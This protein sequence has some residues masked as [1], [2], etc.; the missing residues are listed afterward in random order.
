MTQD[1]PDAPRLR[2]AADRAVGRLRLEDLA[3]GAESSL[4]QVGPEWFEQPANHLAIAIDAEVGIEV[5]SD[6]PRPDQALVISGAA[7]ALAATVGRRIAPRVG[8][9]RAGRV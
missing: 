6:E 8:A 1:F 4:A 7:G 9:R 2:D 3:D 5:R